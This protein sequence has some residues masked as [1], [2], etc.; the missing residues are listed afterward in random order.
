[1][2]VLTS[3]LL[4]LAVAAAAF[5]GLFF[6]ARRLGNFG[7]VDIAWAGGFAP[8]AVFHAVQGRGDVLHRTLL[9][10]MMGTWSLRLGLMLGRHVLG[11]HP[12]E[13]GRYTQLRREWADRLD[14][15][16][17]GF[18]LLQALLLV[19]LSAPVAL[20]VE[21]RRTGLSAWDWVGLAVWAVALLGE[22]VADAQLA[23][24]K[25]DP[26][27]SGQVCDRGLWRYSRH[28]N[29]FFEWLV[30]VGLALVITPVPHGWVA[31]GCPL[32]MGWFLL[33]VTGISYTEAQLLRSK[34]EAYRAYKSRTSAFVP[35]PPRRA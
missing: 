23:A 2:P 6:I 33:R 17:A 18:Y 26:A 3:L 21:A 13:D 19:L 8:V 4:V 7:L 9:A 15:K 10:L 20:A 32:L 22:T 16:M 28:P 5:L 31:W 30:W 25:R 34:G 27:N 1:M 35:W 12:V 29:Y 24:F 11:H 14:V